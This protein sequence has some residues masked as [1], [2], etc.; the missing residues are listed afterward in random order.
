MD[1]TSLGLAPAQRWMRGLG[2]D[3]DTPDIETSGADYARRFAGPAG[4][5]LLEAQRAAAERLLDGRL[6][7]GMTV[8]DV[9]GGHGQ[10]L[11]L[12][13]E[14]GARVWVHG[15]TPACTQRLAP[16]AERLPTRVHFVSSP[17]WNLPFPDG[18]FDLVTGIRLL[19]H[20]ERW[21]EL[22]AEMARLARHAVLADFPPQGGANA[23]TPLLFGL[24]RRLEGNTRPYFRYPPRQVAGA[25]ERL[26]FA[27]VR[28][29]RQLFWPMVL[30]RAAARP[31]LS[32]GAEALARAAGLTARCGGPVLMLAERE[33]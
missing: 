24:K 5:F 12:L 23:A 1:A 18:S 6:R 25:L 32:R 3:T 20:V 14:R 33:G 28:A 26:G 30:H 9:G 13:L 4:A 31:A 27:R 19:A 15:S 10:M 8:L 22:L 29:E 11:P 7:H 21:Q 17:L 16:L 2:H